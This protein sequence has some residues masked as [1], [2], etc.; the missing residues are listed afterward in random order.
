MESVNKCGKNADKTN[1]IIKLSRKMWLLSLLT[2]AALQLRP[3]SEVAAH[4]N[5][6]LNPVEVMRLLG[7]FFLLF[8][9]LL[10]FPNLSFLRPFI[11]DFFS[12]NSTT[13]PLFLKSKQQLSNLCQPI[14]DSFKFSFIL[15]VKKR[16]S[17]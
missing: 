4:L 3:G 17:L 6:F 8:L 1:I 9:F 15:V 2:L 11:I 13:L 7:E 16:T 14:K 12:I 5:V 10:F